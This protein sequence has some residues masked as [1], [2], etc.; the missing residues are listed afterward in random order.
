M[1]HEYRHVSARLELSEQSALAL[2]LKDDCTATLKI[3]ISG[4]IVM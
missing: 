4:K 3:E 1:F 2:R